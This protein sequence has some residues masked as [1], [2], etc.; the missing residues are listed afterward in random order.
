MVKYGGSFP[1]A[2]GDS[3]NGSEHGS[4]RKDGALGECGNLNSA[5]SSHS[6]GFR[7]DLSGENGQQR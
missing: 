1:I 4:T 3:F 7:F 6:S 2:F 5:S